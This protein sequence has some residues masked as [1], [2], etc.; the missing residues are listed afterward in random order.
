[1]DAEP[2]YNRVNSKGWINQGYKWICTPDGREMTEHR[3]FMEQSLGRR[4]H[5]DETVHHINEDK[6]DNRLENLQLLSRVDHAKHHRKIDPIKRVCE[7]CGAEF[8]K[9]SE[10]NYREY[11]TCSRACQDIQMWRT[12]RAS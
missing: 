9:P 4:L 3:W 10:V 5:T 2:Y 8:T 6:L 12:R 7:N 1:M 11:K